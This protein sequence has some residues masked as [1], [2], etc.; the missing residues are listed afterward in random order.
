M[1]WSSATA[2]GRTRSPVDLLM[3]AE[4]RST[5]LLYIVLGTDAAADIDV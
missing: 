2:L 3:A 5:S 4:D 1:S